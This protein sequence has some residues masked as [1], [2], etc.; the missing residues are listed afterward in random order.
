MRRAAFIKVE[1]YVLWLRLF[2]ALRYKNKD[3]RKTEFKRLRYEAEKKYL[4]RY[5]CALDA[6]GS[7]RSP[8]DYLDL[9]VAGRRKF[10]ADG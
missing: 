5:L 2:T 4:N 10:A 6:V 9:L 1:L 3:E 8:E 7:D